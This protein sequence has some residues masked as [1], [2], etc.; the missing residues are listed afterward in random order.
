M[1]AA[2]A[3]VAVLYFANRDMNGEPDAIRG[4]GRYH[5]VLARGDGHML[6]LMA[7]STALD[8]DWRF[9]N[10][11]AR[12]G[13][14]W[15]EPVTAT[16]R[17]SIIHP[18]GCALVW[19][20]LIWLAEAGAAVANIFGA[21][22]AMHGYT[23]WH[24]RIVFLSSV[25]FAC[26]AVL[27]GRRLAARW[28]CGWAPTYAAI[29]VLLG[30]PLTYYA[31]NMPSYA[32]AL[33]SFACSAFLA[34]WALTAGR[35]DWKRFAILGLLLGFAA[36]V[37]TQELALGIVVAFEV[38]VRVIRERNW[39]WLAGGALALAV[40]VVV[41]I[42]QFIEWQ[43][44]FG[45][46]RELPQGAR[47]TRLNAP[48]I[49]ELL[50]SA[51]NGWFS[52]TPIAYAAVIGLV[53]VP[54]PAR[55]VAIGLG[56][57]VAM[58]IYLNST[59]LDWWGN[60]AF[61]QRRLCNVTLPLVVGL[62]SLGWRLGRL[63][64]PRIGA[65]VTRIGLAIV[66]APF[67]IWNVWRVEQLR[68]GKPAPSELE[69]TCCAP[70]TP[71]PIAW[72]Y[73]HVGDPFEFPANAIFALSH[74]VGLDRWDHAV[75]GYPVIPGLADLKDDRLWNV[76]GQW[77]PESGNFAP[78]LLDG[79]T[80]PTTIDGRACR[81]LVGDEATL[82]V[83]NLMPDRERITL[84]VHGDGRAQFAW[85]GRP[86]ADMTLVPGWQIVELGM[87]EPGLHTNELAIHA[88]GAC[89][90]TIDVAMLRPR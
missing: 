77:H 54:K 33:D 42:P 45:T 1:L 87:H 68:N 84:W 3:L 85:N 57:V 82:L 47:Y 32:H 29:A 5:P 63:L 13:D 88:R 40:A 20:P 73:D 81:A 56:I 25:L 8:L 59:I 48:M 11:L 50:W 61:G 69:P 65:R 62:A 76:R 75:G 67:V 90:G 17:K 27:L 60:A 10:D 80:A 12:F 86:V 46:F 55:F 18:I 16:G 24:Q 41:L 28:L 66:L 35:V 74:H 49:G 4:D 52:T 70:G 43:I 30:T 53:C 36:L 34:Y 23:M 89:I 21:D 72:L 2:C 14:P 83:P 78:Y 79:W 39:R 7:R 6:Y 22:I 37:R 15:H 51:R 71:S 26:G 44:V 19:T 58:Q 9:D 64:V 38:A 31:T